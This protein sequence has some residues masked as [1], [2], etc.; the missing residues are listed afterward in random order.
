MALLAW[1]QIVSFGKC[2][3]FIGAE[4]EWIGLNSNVRTDGWVIPQHEPGVPATNETGSP[5]SCS[6]AFTVVNFGDRRC[7]P[8]GCLRKSPFRP[9]LLRKLRGR[10]SVL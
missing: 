4:N 10:E 5:G 7:Q 2:S 1:S 9:E 6:S 8:A 3:S